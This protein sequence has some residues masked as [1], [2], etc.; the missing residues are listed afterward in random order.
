MNSAPNFLDILDE[1]FRTPINSKTFFVDR[2]F[3]IVGCV[4]C[5]CFTAFIGDDRLHLR[6]DEGYI[7]KSGYLDIFAVDPHFFT[8]LHEHLLKHVC[9]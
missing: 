7:F 5:S 1:W 9:S 3:D 8:Q 6:L 2:E 4:H